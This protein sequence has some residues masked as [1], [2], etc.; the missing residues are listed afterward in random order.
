VDVQETLAQHEK[1][2]SSPVGQQGQQAV[3]EVVVGHRLA[4]DLG[5]LDAAGGRISPL[6]SMDQQRMW[7]AAVQSECLSVVQI[8][9]CCCTG[10]MQRSLMKACWIDAALEARQ[11][12]Y[13]AP[14]VGC[15]L[16][17][18]MTQMGK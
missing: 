18:Q 8:R 4:Q 6:L 2:E 7:T 10:Y 17:D 9:I 5:A 11:C 14:W 3:E 12:G 1:T 13:V 16:V 15:Y